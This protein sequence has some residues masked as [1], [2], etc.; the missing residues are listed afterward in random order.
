MDREPHPH[1]VDEAP[2]PGQAAP[3]QMST[4]AAVIGLRRRN[5]RNAIKAVLRRAWANVA[6]EYHAERLGLLTDRYKRDP[7]EQYA[8]CL[9]LDDPHAPPM[10]WLLDVDGM[11][12]ESAVRE[13][14]IERAAREKAKGERR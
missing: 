8:R 10:A 13:M 6:P 9:R 4:C 3:C 1:D 7:A 2:P 14:R 12:F 5:A 11:E